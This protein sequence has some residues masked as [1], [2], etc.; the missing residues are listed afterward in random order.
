VGTDS[1]INTFSKL[2][3]KVIPIPIQSTKNQKSA[4][5][6]HDEVFD[7]ILKIANLFEVNGST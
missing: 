1:V 7:E 3:I 2:G 6:V 4:I 5:E